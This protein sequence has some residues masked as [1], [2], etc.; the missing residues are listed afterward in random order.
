MELWIFLALSVPLLWAVVNLIDDNLVNHVYKGADLAAVVSGFFGLLPA[1][2][3]FFRV[4]GDI[5]LEF[6]LVVLS[7]TAGFL[8]ALFYYFYFRALE[9]EDPSVVVALFSLTPALIPILAYVFVGERLSVGALIGFSIVVI[10]AVLYAATDIRKFKFSR[11]LVPAIIAALII[12]A[13]AIINK[14]IYNQADFYVSYFYFSIGLFLG[15]L[16]FFY[17]VLFLGYRFNPRDLIRKNSV[18]LLGLLMLVEL[19]GVLAEYFK[20]LA[21]SQGPV[22]LISALENLQVVYI[23]IISLALFPFFPKY[24]SEAKARYMGLKFVLAGLMIGGV[25]LAVI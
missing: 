19:I 18:A 5:S 10:C 7:L 24:F 13:V 25:Y 9:R 23:L 15:G 4:S 22:S 3:V 17:V 11:A 6:H 16:Y 8:T 2:Y 1:A 12:D 20:N 14:Y 21:I